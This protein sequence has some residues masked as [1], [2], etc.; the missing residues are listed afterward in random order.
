MPK[1][2]AETNSK[3]IRYVR[4]EFLTYGYE[5]ASLN[6]VSAKVGITTAGLY[7]H[8]K[9]KEDMFHYLVKDVLEDFERVINGDIDQMETQSDYNPFDSNW[10]DFWVN[11]IY[12]HFEGLQ[13][14]LCCSKGSPYESFEEDLIRKETEANIEYA[15]IIQENTGIHQKVS[16]MQWHILATAYIHLIF[17]IV[18]HNMTKDEATEHLQFVSKLLYPGWKQLLG[19]E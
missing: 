9:N 14:L 8:F 2:K 1:D 15:R 10:A 18:R 12:D 6:R 3:I 17:E 19:I 7:K 4:E 16:D 5:K 13:L 11:F